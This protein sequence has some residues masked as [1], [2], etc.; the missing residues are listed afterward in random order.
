M[1]IM[2][3]TCPPAKDQMEQMKYSLS[4]SSDNLHCPYEYIVSVS[5]LFYQICIP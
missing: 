4:L 2:W 1:T 3:M 5:F